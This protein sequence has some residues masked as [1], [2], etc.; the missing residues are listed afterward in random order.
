[1]LLDAMT[2][3]APQI[4]PPTQS[5]VMVGWLAADMFI[6]GIQGA[7]DCLT[8]ERFIHNLRAVSDYNGGGLLAQPVDFARTAT[9]LST[10]YQFLQI[11]ADGRRFIPESG[12]RC[13]RLLT[14]S[15][16]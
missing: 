16:R 2:R 12:L 14:D 9:E 5:S 7:G 8:R 15:R 6:R 1:M 11:S 3:Y 4:Q 10:C 13:G